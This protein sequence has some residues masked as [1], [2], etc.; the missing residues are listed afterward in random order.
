MTTIQ[1]FGKPNC[2]NNEKQKMVLRTAGH[3]VIEHDITSCDFTAYS[4]RSYFGDIP[5]V[6]WFNVTAPAIKTG[7][8]D[9]SLLGAEEALQAMLTDRLLIRRPL[10]QLGDI[11]MCGFDTAEIDATLALLPQTGTTESISTLLHEDIVT[12]PN[13]K[14]TSCDSK[15]PTHA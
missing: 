10:L 1:F 6:N 14:S 11:R 9:P 15:G 12:C 13:L 2:R 7:T 5:V 8:V 3:T 4:L